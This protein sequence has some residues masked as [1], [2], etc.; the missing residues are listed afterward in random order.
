MVRLNLTL[1]DDTYMA[2]EKHAKRLGKP[3]A[4]VAKDLLT[5]GLARSAAAE[6]RKKLAE[7]YLA[8]RAAARESLKDW[9]SPQFEIMG[10]EED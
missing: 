2:L 8:D 4:R 3:C 6:R 9:E 1:A 10:N 7:D 5:E